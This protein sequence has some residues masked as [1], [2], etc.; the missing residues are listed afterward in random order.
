MSLANKLHNH[1]A[2]LLL[3]ILLKKRQYFITSDAI[4]AVKAVDAN[5]L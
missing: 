1:T 4:N 3:L 5:A 2:H